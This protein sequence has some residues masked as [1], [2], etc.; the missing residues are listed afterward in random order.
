M[1]ERLSRVSHRPEPKEEPKPAPFKATPVPLAVSDTTRWRE[2]QLRDAGRAEKIGIDAQRLQQMASLPPRMAAYANEEQG[3]RREA[4][5]KI[6]AVAEKDATFTPA[7]TDDVPDFKKK[8]RQFAAML[9]HR[10]QAARMQIDARKKEVKPFAF[11]TDA[12]MGQDGGNRPSIPSRN[13]LN[14]VKLDQRRDE[15]FL[16]EQRWPYLSTRAEVKPRKAPDFA[17]LHAALPHQE[18]TNSAELRRAAVEEE[19]LKQQQK[20]AKEARDEEKRQAVMKANTERIASRIGAASKR[21]ESLRA[22]QS[23]EEKK[24]EW[25]QKERDGT[26]SARN[27]PAQS[28]RNSGSDFVTATFSDA[29]RQL[30]PATDRMTAKRRKEALKAKME[31][32]PLMCESK[33]TERERAR[34]EAVEKFEKTLVAQGLGDVL[35]IG[36]E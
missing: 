11:R 26:T 20:E 15:L 36:L 23:L 10:K 1:I 33:T 9:E 32:K 35:G 7:I 18:T 22:S 25:R 24:K 30:P 29:A 12:R 34:E 4:L 27:S 16:P 17:G 13:T 8:Q 2:M 31:A 19:L 6:K 14:E 28:P 5:Q 21:M 3:K